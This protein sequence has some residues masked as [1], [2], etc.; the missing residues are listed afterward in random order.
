MRD[1]RAW[2]FLA[3]GLVLAGL[4]GFALYGLAQ[5]AAPAGTARGAP[6]QTMD[7]LVAKSDLPV[8]VII[9]ADAV[10][11]KSYPLDLV[12]AGAFTNDA[13]VV[14]QTTITSIARGQ[15]IV[16]AQLSLAGGDR[17]SSLTVAKG[18]VM[19]AFPTTDP[20]TAAGLVHIGDRVDV[21]ASV[22]AGTGENAK[23]SQTTIQNLEV[24]DILAPTSA[25]PQRATALVFAVDHQ[26]ALV[27]KYLRDAQATIDLAIRSQSESELTRTTSV[28]LAYIVSTYGIR[29]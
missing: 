10:M 14:G 16:Q 2:I 24:L 3:I 18:M 6:A 25:Q 13:D 15:A 29:K 20:L 4:T 11:R 5:Q 28:D 12:P 22:I 1:T 17:S 8:R 23:V 9:T 19:V 27:L 21:L 26:V 7:I